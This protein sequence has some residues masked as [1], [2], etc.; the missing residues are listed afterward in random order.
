MKLSNFAVGILAVW[1]FA[2]C[3]PSGLNNTETGG[4]TAEKT[5]TADASTTGTAEAKPRTVQDGIIQFPAQ[6]IPPELDLPA[7]AFLADHLKET[8]KR[9]GIMTIATV[10]DPKT[11]DPITS[12]ESSSSEINSRLFDSLL[13]FDP[14][15]Q[16]YFPAL[17]KEMTV[18]E[19]NKTWTLKLRENLKWSDGHPLTADD[20]IFTSQIIFDKNIISPT[21]DIL[22]VGNEP[23][24]FEK[25][26]DLAVKVTSPKPTG[27]MHVMLATFTPVPKHILEPAYN[28]G[29][30][31]TAMNVNIAP[32][33]LVGS[34]AFKLKTYQPAERVV[35]E[36]N[37]NYYR[38]DKNKTQ[39]PYLDQVIFSINPDTDSTLAKFRSGNS[40]AITP[41]LES[42]PDLKDLEAK[43]NFTLY[44]LGPAQSVNFFWFNLKQGV[45]PKNQKPYVHPEL[46]AIFNNLNFRKAVLHALNRDAFVASVLR[47]LGLRANSE[48]SPALKDWFNPNVDKYDY[49]VNKS[50][51]LL[52]E[53]GFIDRDGDGIREASDGTKL[54]FT[55]ITNAENKT[56]IE[57]GGLIAKDLRAVGID[58]RLQQVD[59]NTL[60]TQ[61][62]DSFQYEGVLLGF[63]GSIHP[64]TSMNSWRSSGRT[65]FW[66]PLQEKPVRPW[67]AEI[68]KLCDQFTE[69]LEF[70]KQQEIFFQMQKIVSENVPNMPLFVP[71]NFSAMRNKFGNVRPTPLAD[72]FW[73]TDELFIK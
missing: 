55:F 48:T 25:I 24:K 16:T 50:N 56:R 69:T 43:E 23:L 22:K 32:E 2:G 29:T 54:S 46:S 57:L 64:I 47:G 9:G 53:A 52:E 73:N 28:N 44:D 11:F 19:D 36:R 18:A 51:A 1:M 49:D 5:V 4:D 58:A 7:G 72:I 38:Y 15:N 63:T 13:S 35:I 26:D 14:D 30:Y 3:A 8:G 40:D 37:P 10:G 31:E 66:D 17:L 39:L 60:V 34:G 65:H 42:V 61:L 70:S 67:E 20:I 12:N 59:F 27:F 41:R 68:D 21:A 62:N 6:Q 71:K 45:N 33:K